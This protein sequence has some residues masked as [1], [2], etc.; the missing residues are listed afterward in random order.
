MIRKS[1][2]LILRV[3]MKKNKT[4]TVYDV[5]ASG[6]EKLWILKISGVS[7]SYDGTYPKLCLK[8]CP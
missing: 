6:M 8:I 2:I 7:P 5:V 1:F 4:T 3:R